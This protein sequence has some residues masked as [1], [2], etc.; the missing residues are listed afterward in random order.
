MTDHRFPIHQRRSCDEFHRLRKFY[1]AL[2][3]KFNVAKVEVSKGRH[4]VT[5]ESLSH[6][7]LISPEAER[8]TVQH[9]T[10]R[11]IMM[12]LHPSLLRKFKTNNRELR[13]NRIQHS[14]FTN[15][16]KE[17]NISRRGNWYAQVYSTYFGWSREQP[18]KRKG[19][20]NE[21]MSLFFKRAGVPPRMVMDG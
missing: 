19:Y 3:A 12:I 21:T 4:G 20:A 6:K 2:N 15:K 16:M 1:K 9:T 5:L 11:G 8:R 17:A 14:V 18:M 7:W 10:K 13:K